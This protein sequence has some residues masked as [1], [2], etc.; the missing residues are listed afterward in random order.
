MAEH[1]VA[2]FRVDASL[3]IGSGHVMRCLTLAAALRD[4]GWHCTFVCREHSGHLQAVIAAQGHRVVRLAAPLQQ[5]PQDDHG[6]AHSRWLA[7]SQAVDAAETA[8]MLIQLQPQLLVV[9]HYGID[10]HWE[11]R[12]LPLVKTLFVIDDLGDRQH[13]CHLLLDQNAGRDAAD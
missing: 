10:A 9:D 12:L 13:V 8:E 1:R 6:T 11:A 2:A 3:Q 5:P 4:Q 7:C